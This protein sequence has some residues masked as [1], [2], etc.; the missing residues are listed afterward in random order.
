[1]H[2]NPWLA[3]TEASPIAETRAWV[4]GRTF[5]ADKP[6]INLSQAVPGYSP[7]PALIDHLRARLGDPAM[8][9]YVDTLGD[10]GLREAYAAH[11]SGF[12][13]A[14]VKPAEVAITAGCN[15]AFCLA[16]MALAKAGEQVI[17]PRPH[18]FNHDMWMRMQGI[19]VVPLDFRPGSGAIPAAE[20]AARLITPRTRAIVLV[21]PN[22]PTGA[23]YPP[24]VIRAFY[25]LAQ[26]HGI[27][28]ILDET[29][30][31]FIPGGARPHDLFQDPDWRRTAVHLYS[32]SKVFA[33][34]GYRVGAVT[35][36]APMIA[37]IEKAL[38]CVSIC[39]PRLAQ[40]A[41][42]FGLGNLGP[43]VQGNV[44]ALQARAE[45]FRK[46]LARANRWRLVSLGAYF[47]YIEHPFDGESALTVARRLADEAN[48]L[49][50]PGTMFGAGQ[51]RFIRFA[52]ANV[53][54]A[55]IPR[56]FDRLAD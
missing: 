55:D 45:A 1:M 52:F 12:Y 39:A 9:R 17:L 25:A 50:I 7:P 33:L 15:Q 5:P 3:A 37:E 44:A 23:I 2:V 18:Y 19:D 53:D 27:A 43:W 24:D 6:L 8:H 36:G 31:D 10:N 22:N 32:F 21:T 13:G 41:A 51:D 11:L 4:A 49:T 20:D 42:L 40:E 34:T 14:A 35:T 54:D 38:D 30:K 28:L 47:A 46:G 16:V 56:V 26:R 29:Y 48:L